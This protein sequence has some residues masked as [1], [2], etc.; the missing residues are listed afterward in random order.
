MEP[1]T[2]ES[3]VESNYDASQIQVLK[4]LSAVRVRPAMYIGSVSHGQAG[5]LGSCGY[6]H[7]RCPLSAKW[8]MLE[9]RHCSQFKV[10]ITLSTRVADIACSQPP[11]APPV[12]P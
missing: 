2:K 9:A 6:G 5:F 1:D 12:M 3:T 4:G 10:V 8:M 11:S 7:G